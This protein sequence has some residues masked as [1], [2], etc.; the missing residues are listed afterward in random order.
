MAASARPCGRRVDGSRVVRGA[1]APSV[2]LDRVVRRQRDICHMHIGRTEVRNA[3]LAAIAR[4]MVRVHAGTL[5]AQRVRTLRSI[6][7]IITAPRSAAIY[8][9]VPAACCCAVARPLARGGPRHHEAHTR[10]SHRAAHASGFPMPVRGRCTR[11]WHQYGLAYVRKGRSLG[12]DGGYCSLDCVRGFVG[13]DGRV[14]ALGRV[15]VDDGLG[16]LMECD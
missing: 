5:A 13:V 4:R 15:V 14:H 12:E 10:F 11:P 3:P 16:L 8:A 9:R 2:T 6:K 7:K 1:H